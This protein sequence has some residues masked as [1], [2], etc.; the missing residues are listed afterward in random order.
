MY[1]G[2]NINNLFVHYESKKVGNFKSILCLVCYEFLKLQTLFELCI[3]LFSKF[4]KKEREEKGSQLN[5][6]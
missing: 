2:I 3:S 4:I 1:T 6:Y 5:F